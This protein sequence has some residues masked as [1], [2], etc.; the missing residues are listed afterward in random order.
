M[1][2]QV[3]KFKFEITEKGCMLKSYN[4]DDSVVIIPQKHE[5]ADVIGIKSAAFCS[6][7]NR[8]E[9]IVLHSKIKEVTGASFYESCN[10]L[11]IAIDQDNPWFCSENGVLFTKDKSKLVSFPA[12]RETA[13]ESLFNGEYVIGSYAFAFNN[14]SEVI[15]CDK[16]ID[17]EKAAFYSS[18][19]LV[20]CKLPSHMTVI[21][22]EV[23][24][25]SYYLEEVVGE[26]VR[27]VGID[28]FSYCG[29]IKGVNYK[30]LYKIESAAFC[31]CMGIEVF[32]A[33][34]S[35][36][37]IAHDDWTSV[38]AF[39]GC[40]NLREII[41]PDG[42]QFYKS[43]DGVLFSADST[44]LIFYPNGKK[45]ITYKIPEGVTRIRCGAFR[46]VTH[47]QY[48]MMPNS[49]TVIEDNAF[50]GCG[51]VDLEMSSNIEEIGDYAFA[52]SKNLQRIVLPES[53]KT[54]GR[55]VFLFCNELHLYCRFRSS[56]DFTGL[57]ETMRHLKSYNFEHECD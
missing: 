46:D 56:K 7:T 10:L 22:E 57:S 34:N 39:S 47:L 37:E 48:L 36:C 42:N 40:D 5:G 50:D 52:N 23:F 44:E 41:I 4:G 1:E 49:V 33:P 51:L 38:N 21:N 24:A 26:N 55:H 6:A 45:N 27:T 20:R 3:E 43:V 54:M 2:K 19:K 16:I 32:T 53:V 28:A 14:L 30:K 35:L 15:L 11:E 25:S 31:R 13:E 12:G 18:R 8:V 9:K 17:I 29:S